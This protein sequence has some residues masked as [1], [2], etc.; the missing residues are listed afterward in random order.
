[1]NKAR[2][3]QLV[4][5][6][7][8]IEAGT[9]RPSGPLADTLAQLNMIPHFDMKDWGEPDDDAMDCGFSACAVGHMLLDER[10]QSQ[11]F[12]DVDQDHPDAALQ[13]GLSP[14]FEGKSGYTA[15]AAFFGISRT[16]AELLFDPDC[17]LSV[18]PTPAAIRDRVLAMMHKEPTE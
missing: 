3:Q 10:F 18:A 14:R 4:D 1:M 13:C 15:P 17:Y 8:E 6:L 5:M 9:W 2:M 12:R 11:G 7:D 16:N